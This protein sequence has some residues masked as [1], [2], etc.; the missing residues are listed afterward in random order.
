[1]T[2]E[3]GPGETRSAAAAPRLAAAERARVR[4]ARALQRERRA[5]VLAVLATTSVAVAIALYL[6]HGGAT[7]LQSPAD[8]VTAAGIVAGLVGTDLVLVMLLLAARIPVVDRTFGRDAVMALHGR[9]GKPALYLLL[10]HGALVLVGYGMTDGLNPVAE[11][12]GL[13]SLGDMVLAILAICLFVTVVVTSLVAIRRRFPYEVWHGIHLLSY[14]AV[15]TALPH[16]LSVGGVLAEGT[17]QRAYW[18]GLTV[19]AIASI[20]WF[21]FLVPVI[22]S[23]RHRLSVE[24]VER[25]SA[26]AVAVHLTGRNLRRL[27]VI[28]GQYAIWRFW[29]AGTWWHAHPIS[30]SSAGDDRRM[31]VTVREL[32]A[33]TGRLARLRPGTRVSIE[34]PYGI[35]TARN[36]RAPHLAVLA[37]GVGVTPV[38]AMLEDAEVAP[39]EVTVLLRAGTDDERYHWH[40]IAELVEE[41]GG[42]LFASV[43]RRPQ[44]TGTWL[45]ASDVARGV[46]LESIF[47][48]VRSSDLFVCGPQAWTDLVVRDALSAGVPAGQIHTERFDW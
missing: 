2:V 14:A 24:R 8:V 21:R 41:R 47:P 3:T 11:L 40:E 37:A 27:R 48:E 39:G 9:L 25:L 43:G 19:L 15:L 42:K 12:I 5:D 31:R 44:G 6:G 33:G 22:A 17:W 7:E 32:G 16:Q 35:F 10:A 38:R 23:L 26:D 45:S 36:R 18:I 29:S 1:M 13:M 46:T 34:G 30:F 4:R 28:G 20:C